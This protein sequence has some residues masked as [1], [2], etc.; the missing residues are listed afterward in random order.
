M[1]ELV[2]TEESMAQSLRSLAKAAALVLVGY[3]FDRLDLSPLELVVPEARILTSVGN[4]YLE[5]VEVLRLAAEGR[6]KPVIHEVAPLTEVN[7]VLEDLRAGQVLGRAIMR[8][9]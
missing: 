3:S 8:P 1:F 5:L 9:S 4:T 7:R 2:G 6:F